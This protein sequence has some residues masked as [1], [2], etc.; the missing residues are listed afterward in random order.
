[1]A[2]EQKK[3]TE[4]ISLEKALAETEQAGGQAAEIEKA[5]SAPERAAE[6]AGFGSVE[7]SEKEKAVGAPAAAKP[8]AV[9]DWQSSNKQ[10]E[11]QIEDVL[12]K[13]LDEA[14]LSMDPQKQR[15][16]KKMGEQTAREI[17][18]LLDQAKVKIKKI[19]TLIRKWL[20]IIPGVNKFFIEQESKIK[21]DEIIK[22]K[23]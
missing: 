1:M 4:H 22:L 8:F 10:R 19:I 20:S 21:A 2:D 14:F 16:F 23:K 15:E 3:L 18:N 7:I 6:R 9:G 17:N 13:G 11:K 12:A 5:P